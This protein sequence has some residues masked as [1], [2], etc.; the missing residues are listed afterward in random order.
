METSD[1]S[2]DSWL[3]SK[4]IVLFLGDRAN[5]ARQMRQ[6]LA[7]TNS[8]LFSCR[9]EKGARRILDK[10]AVD[11]LILQERSMTQ[12]E[13]GSLHRLRHSYPND[14][15]FTLLLISPEERHHV[16]AAF[17]AGID[18]FITVPYDRLAL[19]ARVRTGMRSATLR[20]ELT[21]KN[22]NLSVAVMS[23]EDAFN[24]VG[25][26][27]H[28]LQTKNQELEKLN[29]LK[30][31]MIDIVAHDLRNPMSAVEMYLD[32]LIEALPSLPDE[33]KSFLLNA[34]ILVADGLTMLSELL[35]ISNFETGRIRLHPD[36]V[37]LK[38]FLASIVE[39]MNLLFNQKNIHYELDLDEAPETWI[40]DKKRIEQVL[41]NLLTNA[42]K[43]SERDSRVRVHV[44]EE[45]QFLNISVEDEGQGIPKSEIP[46]IFDKFHKG[47]AKPTADESSTGLGLA[48]AKQIVEQHQGTITVESRVGE[49]SVFTVKMPSHPPLP[50][51]TEETL[52]V[53]DVA[54]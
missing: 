28:E 26:L 15:F 8:R 14:P 35:D 44:S 16:T 20:R 54:Q 49:G 53:A 48:I 24:Q 46:M 42:A 5:I 38:P 45:N 17:E 13:V 11:I 6:D 25:A 22:D 4:G 29:S 41:E 51:H 19:L 36:I 33:P 40:L 23:Y 50:N 30:D 10:C 52:Q 32:Y 43:F 34:K 7:Q 39:R 37:Q 27:A 47:F 18:D 3:P 21:S 1:F 9:T 31:E 12:P 2:S